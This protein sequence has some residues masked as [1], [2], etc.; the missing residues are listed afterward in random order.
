MKDTY[1]I[2]G[3]DEFSLM[4]YNC[5]IPKPKMTDSKFTKFKYWIVQLSEIK[6]FFLSDCFY[7]WQ[8]FFMSF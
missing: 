8:Q 1:I 2:Q 4:K 6:P 7:S 5:R 3:K